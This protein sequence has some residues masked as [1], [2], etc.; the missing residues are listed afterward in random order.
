LYVSLPKQWAN[1]MKLKQGDK[2]LLIPQP[3]GSMHIYPEIT[4]DKPKEKV[5]RVDDR[6]TIQSLRRAI[7]ASYVDGFDLIG[8]KAE[9]GLTEEHQNVIRET[10]DDLFAL[11]LIEVT[12]NS[13][14]IQCLLKE[15][16]PIEKTVQRLHNMI[17]SMFRETV[18]AL[19]ERDINSVKTLIRRKYDIKRLSLVTH[20]ILRSLILFP[21]PN[22]QRKLSLIDCVDYLQIHHM[23]TEIADSISKISESVTVLIGQTLPKH[24][25]GPLYEAC[26]LT[27]DLYDQSIQALLSKD[28]LLANKVLDSKLTLEDLLRLCIEADEKS[29]ISS[30]ALSQA[31]LLIDNLKQIQQYSNEI[32]EIAIDHA[33]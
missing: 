26:I 24:I 22:E 14:T 5:L 1:A 21:T 6:D 25:F 31:Y 8:L 32:A 28:I 27:Q 9:R 7:I 4:E 11:E 20:R 10:I 13:I 30:L 18:S 15:A 19:E 17:L 23:I 2:V 12:R 33:L 3:D 29:E 16:L